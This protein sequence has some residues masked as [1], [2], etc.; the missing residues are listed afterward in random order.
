MSA[1]DAASA[2]RTGTPTNFPGMLGVYLAVNAVP[3]LFA[4]VDGPDCAL[5][6]AH[7]IHGRHDWESTLLRADGRHRVGFTNVC[8]RGVV[9][10]HDAILAAAVRRLDALPDCAAVLVTALPMCSITGVDYGRVTRALAPSLKGAAFDAP[11]G[12][13]VGDWLDGYA[14]ALTALAKAVGP[15]PGRAR[16]GTVAFVGHLMDR[17]EAD[18][19]ADVRELERL[20]EGLGLECVS[21][22]L[23]GKP[24]AQLKRVEEAETVV[25]LPYARGAA[26]LVAERTGARLVEAPLPFGLAK[27]AELARAL[28]AA[29]GRAERAEAFVAAELARV[30]PRFRWVLPHLFVGKRAAFAGDP[31]LF[32]GFA[33]I[34]ADAGLELRAAV[35]TARPAHGGAL[36]V[37]RVEHEP[38]EED[39]E[40]FRALT[41]GVD[42][43]VACHLRS[44]SRLRG[45]AA[46]LEL[47]FPSSG[48]H[49]FFERPTLGFDG[50]AGFLDRMADALG[51]RP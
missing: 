11:P 12:S 38:P 16:P 42:L 32:A 44:L 41:D 26:R 45:R 36:P 35:L 6:K 17:N 24:F 13:L 25:S 1:P 33:D 43:L 49:A 46:I 8:A 2:P 30:V 14:S 4:L 5:Y 7:F 18:R 15:E 47:G 34:A 50:F 27:T 29:T 31:H 10:E 22:W 9:R 3:D 21:V 37:A 40:T 48:H 51:R 39:P 28:G 19:R 20:A 23:S